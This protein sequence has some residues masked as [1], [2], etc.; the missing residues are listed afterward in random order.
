MKRSI[1]PWLQAYSIDYYVE[2]FKLIR[3]AKLA[4]GLIPR[5]RDTNETLSNAKECAIEF[6]KNNTDAKIWFQ[7]SQIDEKSRS[8]MEYVIAKYYGSTTEH[9]W[10]KEETREKLCDMQKF[11][12][13]RIGFYLKDIHDI[14]GKS[15]LTCVSWEDNKEIDVEITVKTEIVEMLNEKNY[16]KIF[17]QQYFKAVSGGFQDAK[18]N[19]QI[20]LKKLLK[21]KIRDENSTG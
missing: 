4:D 9:S 13:L 17:I 2:K 14:N 11:M 19:E 1:D 15:K 21:Q 12:V 7:K 5:D 20:D 3:I 6:I 16:L 18:T 10:T 8:N